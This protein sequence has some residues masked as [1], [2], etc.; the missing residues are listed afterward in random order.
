MFASGWKKA[1]SVAAVV[2]ALSSGQVLAACT[3]GP[4]WTPEE[5]AE[6]QSLNDTAGWAGM[7]KLVQCTV[8]ADEL[9]PA[10][11]QGRI[12]A[13]AGGRQWQ[14]YS[15]SGCSGGQT[16]V[17]SGFGCG[18]CVSATNF[19]FYSGWLWRERSGNPYPTADY[20]TQSGCRGTKLHHQGIEGS[21]T[22]SCN[23]VT[24][25]ASV[26]LYQGC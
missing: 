4:G 20:Y 15:A 21:Q 1:L 17:T 18:V 12:E 3:D 11:S 5:F 13:R 7:E 19:Y 9:T 25:A 10:K 22:S 16:A 14:G 8:N 24:R 2:L 23:D 26:I 6:Y